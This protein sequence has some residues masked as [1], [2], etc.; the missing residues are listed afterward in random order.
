MTTTERYQKAIEKIG[1]AA[2]L[3]NLPEQIREVLMSTTDMETKTTMLELI[4]EAL[5]K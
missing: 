4:A 3:L 2:A 1:G 5:D